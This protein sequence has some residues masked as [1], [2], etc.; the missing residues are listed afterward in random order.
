MPDYPLVYLIF[1]IPDSGR[2]EIIFDLITDG[3]GSELSILY[4]RP[5]GETPCGF[6][7]RIEAL[8]NVC[9]VD[10]TL[11]QTKV[12]HGKID[13]APELILFLAPG[14][15]DPSDCAEAVKSW[16]DHNE[17]QLGRVITVVHCGFLEEKPDALSWHKACIH[18]SDVILLNRRE[19]NSN[20]WLKNFKEEFKQECSPAR[21]I[22]VKKG[23]VPNPAEILEPEPRRLSLFFD[24]LL[25]I[26]EDGLK[27][28]E[29]PEDRRPDKY[30]ERLENGQRAYK[31]RPITGF[32]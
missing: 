28:D 14:T 27:E 20:R 24:E 2:R 31:I 6:D 9:K 10:W 4:F 25:P 11:N 26:E 8:E 16:M 32:L 3:V 23:Q 30:I 13:A 17:C 19:S 7:D 22:L 12:M 15:S 18:F 29:Q 1:G 5:K 21:F